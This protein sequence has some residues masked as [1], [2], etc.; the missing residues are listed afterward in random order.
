MSICHPLGILPAL[1][2]SNEA[3]PTADRPSAMRTGTAEVN[4]GFAYHSVC[5]RLIFALARHQS[6][7]TNWGSKE[8]QSIEALSLGSIGF[9]FYGNGNLRLK[10]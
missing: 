10:S 9:S 3:E 2:N 8:K 6:R 4:S 1:S 5:N 7:T